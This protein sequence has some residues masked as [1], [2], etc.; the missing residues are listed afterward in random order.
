MDKKIYI[1]FFDREVD[2]PIYET[3]DTL[4]LPRQCELVVIKNKVYLV[5]YVKHFITTNNRF[6]NEI[7]EIKIFLEH[8]RDMEESES[9]YGL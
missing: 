6:P 7:Q 4:L 3:S 1:N 2:D 8:I 5:R 9:G